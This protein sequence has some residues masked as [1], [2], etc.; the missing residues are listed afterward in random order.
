MS[1]E[2]PSRVDAE[3]CSEADEVISSRDSPEE[4]LE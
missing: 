4:T 1:T 3:G 2:I